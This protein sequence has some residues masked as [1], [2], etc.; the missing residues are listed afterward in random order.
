MEESV[1]AARSLGNPYWISYV[2]W[3]VGMAFAKTDVRRVR[4][5]GRGRR[6]RA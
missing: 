3:I 1:A 2:L 4:G 5:L 6:L